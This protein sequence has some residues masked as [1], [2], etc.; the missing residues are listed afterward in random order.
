[1]SDDA[2]H[3]TTAPYRTRETHGEFEALADQIYR[4]RV[5][6]ARRTPPEE[7][8]LAGQR[9]FESACEVTLLGI[10]NQFPEASEARCR[11][12]LRERLAMRR[13]REATE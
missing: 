3:D 8:I 5:L 6:R 1:M 12:I 10:R 2:L 9:L 7:K 11:E 4:E 13:R